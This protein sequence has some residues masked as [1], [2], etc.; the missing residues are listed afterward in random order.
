[1]ST[2][3]K[4]VKVDDPAITEAP[5]ADYTQA[6]VVD[7]LLEQKKSVEAVVDGYGCGQSIPELLKAILTE[8]V[9]IRLGGGHV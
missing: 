3:K 9:T 7:A 8:L 1:M 4:N 2:K 5:Y 6:S